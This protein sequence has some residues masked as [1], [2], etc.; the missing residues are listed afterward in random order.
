MTRRRVCLI[1]ADFFPNPTGG[2]GIYT[3][4]LARRLARWGYDVSV[5]TRRRTPTPDGEFKILPVH[6]DNLALFAIEAWL[7]YRTLSDSFDVIH[8][9]D[10]YHL[11]FLLRRGSAVSVTTIH[12]THLQRYRACASKLRW[13]FLFPIALEKY[14][15]R[16]SER[17]IAVSETT[18]A[19]LLEY[20]IE[21][22]RVEI[23]HNG[24]DTAMFNASKRGTFRRKAGIGAG[25]K[26][27]LFVG[28]LV[29][30]KRPL[31]VL[32]AFHRL[33]VGKPDYHLVLVGSG[34][35]R[36]GLED[37]VE[38][39]RLSKS[40]HL[41]GFVGNETLPEIYADSDVF[42]LISSG[43]GLP[44]AALEA[45]ASGCKLVL[46]HDASGGAKPLREAAQVLEYDANRHR[47]ENKILEALERKSTAVETPHIS[48]ETC[49]RR[50]VDLYEGVKNVAL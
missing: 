49:V 36:R 18:L 45:L 47:L 14:A 31:E 29:K 26:V 5:I 32:K 11:C 33:Y 35:L 30:R 15:C 37:Y 44:L 48:I 17:I 43:E 22:E 42:V 24:I 41:L 20:G 12:N 8:G 10:F 27:I 40:V 1:C 46:T 34:P 28:R 4:E 7:R 19:A 38:R 50:V 9:N 21:K 16:R 3:Y 25:D 2:Q 13:L 6:F 39:H 23:I